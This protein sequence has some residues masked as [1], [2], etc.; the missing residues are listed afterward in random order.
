MNTRNILAILVTLLAQS[1]FAAEPSSITGEGAKAVYEN[2]KFDYG[3]TNA[4]GT[5]RY[6]YRSDGEI[7]VYCNYTPENEVLSKK[8]P[9]LAHLTY[10]CAF[11]QR[12]VPT[13]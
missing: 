13:Q 6:K 3:V 12:E 5:T 2:M 10:F 9:N 4:K 7:L 11:D 1:S 8:Y